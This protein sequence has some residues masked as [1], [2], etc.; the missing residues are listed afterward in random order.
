MY[1]NLYKGVIDSMTLIEFME[2]TNSTPR[3]ISDF[4][5]TGDPKAFVKKLKSE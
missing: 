4:A 2:L 3:K 5:P 1:S